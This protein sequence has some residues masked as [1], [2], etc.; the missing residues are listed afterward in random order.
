MTRSLSKT[1]VLRPHSPQT[2]V[3]LTPPGVS[4]PRSDPPSGSP[5]VRLPQTAFW[6]AAAFAAF[7][8]TNPAAAQ[9]SLPPMNLGDSAFQDGIAG[10]SRMVQGSLSI[11]HA[12]RVRNA[13]GEV[14]ESPG[15]VRSMGVVAHAAWLT[16]HQVFGAWWGVE[17]ILPV[18]AVDVSLPGRSDSTLAIGDLVVSPVILQ[19]PETKLF[20]RSYWQRLNFN[21]AIPTGDYDPTALSIGSNAWRFNPHYAFTWEANADW[22]LSGRLHYLWTGRNNRPPIAT[23]AESTQPGGAVHVNGSVSRRWSDSL[24]L[25]LSAYYLRQLADDRIDNTR[26]PGGR[27]RVLGM[28]PA[29]SWNASQGTWHGAAYWETAV[30]DR[31]ESVRASLR[32]V[33]TF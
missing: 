16:E 21:V 3:A 14:A 28:G 18:A 30:R 11:Q 17:A 27:E 25:G 1:A 13:K 8:T 32:Y 9:V 26:A 6:V 24:R 33:Q 20:G 12:D 2:P 5:V 31:P 7:A 10:P 19:W 22:E 15:S 4:A 23:G 29:F